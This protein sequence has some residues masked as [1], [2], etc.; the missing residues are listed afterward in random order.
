[1]FRDLLLSHISGFCDLSASQLNQ[2]EAH[3]ELMVRWN[4]TLNLTRIDSVEAAVERHYTE[5]LFLASKLPAGPLKI[6]DVGAGAGF[7]GIP[8]AVLRPECSIT[9]IESH[10]RKAVFLKEATRS[11]SNV[12]VTARR[13]EEV[14]QTFDWI[15]SRAVSWDDLQ[16]FALHL[17]PNLALLCTKPPVRA[18]TVLDVSRGTFLVLA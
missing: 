15:V 4:K 10:K 18:K 9:L 13:A 11:L 1:M 2:L 5:S 12:T 17:A 8:L 6:A 7:P 3:F 16:K 14:F